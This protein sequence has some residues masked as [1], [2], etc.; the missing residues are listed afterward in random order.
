MTARISLK[1][2]MH[3]RTRDAIFLHAVPNRESGMKIAI[4][5]VN[6]AACTL[7]RYTA[8]EM[9]SMPLS[10]ILGSHTTGAEYVSRI[11]EDGHAISESIFTARDG[12]PVPVELET[13]RLDIDGTSLCMTIAHDISERQSTTKVLETTRRELEWANNAKHQFLANMN[14]ELRTPLNGF[15]GMTQILMGTDLTPSQREYLSLSQDAARQLTKVLTD[16]LSLS[17]VESGSLEL[18]ATTFDLRSTLQSL[19]APLSRQAEEKRLALSLD[20]ADDVP[21]SIRGDVSKLRQILINLLFNALR[22]TE[23]GTVT[24][25]VS[26]YETGTGKGRDC[27]LIFSVTDTGIGITPEKQETIFDS[28]ALAEDYLTKEYGGAGL[29][30]TIS[31][32]LAHIM[33]GSL[34]V[35]SEPGKGSTF[36]LVLP[37]EI[38]ERT[39]PPSV[40]QV[41]TDETDETGLKILLAE[42]EQVNSIMASRLLKKAGHAVTIVGNGQQAIEALSSTPFD[43][44]LMDVQMPVVNGIQ[45]T[46]IIRGGGVENVP[47]DLPIIGLTAF[48]RPSEKKLFKDAGM[49]QVITKPYEADELI[50]AVGSIRR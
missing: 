36:S 40:R 4:T 16:L 33:Q 20:I 13:H 22:F 10:D 24:L 47:K 8:E 48:A 49:E 29:G 27:S 45:A 39:A 12:S 7:L 35:D 2:L 14:H 41:Q 34:S 37:F 23:Q 19:V 25:S 15:L 3:L 38:R 32:Q 18:D 17:N 11:L 43:V 31:R 5:D 30:L 50:Q 46:R 9:C 42:D 1:D 21:G 28:F 26:V 44:V 6:E